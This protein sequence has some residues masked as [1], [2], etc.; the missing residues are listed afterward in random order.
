[1]LA[2]RASRPPSSPAAARL[3]DAAPGNSASNTSSRARTTSA[4][5][6]TE[7]L[8]R[9]GLAAEATAHV[10]RRHP[11]P[12]AVPP[13]R[14]RP[15]ARQ[16]ASGA[17]IARPSRHRGARRRRRGPRG[18]RSDHDAQR[19]LGRRARALSLRP[20][21]PAGPPADPRA[22]RPHRGRSRPRRG[23]ARGRSRAGARRRC[24]RASA[25]S[26]SPISSWRPPRSPSSRRDG[27]LAGPHPR[28][29]DRPLPGSGP[30][31]AR[32]AAPDPLPRGRAALG[33]QRPSGRVIGGTG[34]L[35]AGPARIR[36]VGPADPG[37]RD[38]RAA[39]RR[40]SA[41]PAGP[42]KASS[43]CTRKR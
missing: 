36:R 21:C 32:R 24:R 8:A 4:L 43:N 40:A 29:R 3:V 25:I 6:F 35:D 5:R 28:R 2:A 27:D 16:P 23:P 38:R 33:S 9:T 13:R 22:R 19:H 39:G 31:A 10:G 12:A 18:V 34:L 30:H 7:L 11:G 42:A 20:A 15:R 14:L 17:A 26:A 37:A 1:M 41:A